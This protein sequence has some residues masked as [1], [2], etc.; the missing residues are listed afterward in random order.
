MSH[1]QAW[2]LSDGGLQQLRI[3]V[4]G[5]LITMAQFLFTQHSPGLY[6][7]SLEVCLQVGTL[8]VDTMNSQSVSGL[9]VPGSMLITP[10]LG[11]ASSW[12]SRAVWTCCYSLLKQDEGFFLA[13][14]H[15]LVIH[16]NVHGS[17]SGTHSMRVR[18]GRPTMATVHSDWLISFFKSVWNHKSTT[19]VQRAV[20]HLRPCE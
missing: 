14:A 11:V 16:S 12:S 2:G 17:S 7:A 6:S 5:S 3:D 4:C 18:A 1:S 8:P 10:D 19:T 20:I 9:S 13:T 15:S